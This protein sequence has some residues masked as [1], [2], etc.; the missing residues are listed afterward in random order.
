MSRCQS[1]L[2][3][4]S[5][6]PSAGSPHTSHTDQRHPPCPPQCPRCHL[7]KRSTTCVLDLLDLLVRFSLPAVDLTDN[8]EHTPFSNATELETS[9]IKISGTPVEAAGSTC[10][11]DLCPRIFVN[12]CARLPS[13]I[14]RKILSSCDQNIFWYPQTLDLRKF[15]LSCAESMSDSSFCIRVCSHSQNC[16]QLHDLQRVPNEEPLSRTVHDLVLF[17]LSADGA[18]SCA[19]PGS[20]CLPRKQDHH[21]PLASMFAGRC[22]LR[23]AQRVSAQFWDSIVQLA[24]HIKCNFWSFGVCPHEH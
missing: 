6:H 14:T 4:V 1:E 21:E 2:Q 5:E 19:V 17:G 16:V 9:H 3:L 7:Q 24:S 22:G 23:L 12:K 11:V 10:D 20:N 15:H 8:S 18:T 13:D